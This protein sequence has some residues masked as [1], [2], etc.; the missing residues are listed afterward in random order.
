MSSTRAKGRISADGRWVGTSNQQ[1]LSELLASREDVKVSH[2]S[3]R[4]ILQEAGIQ[5]PRK[6]K[7][8]RRHHQLYDRAH[9]TFG[10]FAHARI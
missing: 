5:S 7:R 4:R 1:H 10:I 8:H 3:V 9:W 2:S 6:Q